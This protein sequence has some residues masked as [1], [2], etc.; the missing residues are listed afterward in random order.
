MYKD[1]SSTALFTLS[2]IIAVVP[3]LLASAFGIPL[4]FM[5]LVFAEF[6]E[7]EHLKTSNRPKWKR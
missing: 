4:L 6:V 7:V 1:V 2:I 3:Y 5:L